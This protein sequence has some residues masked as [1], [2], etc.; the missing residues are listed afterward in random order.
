ML[1]LTYS[2][3]QPE[4]EAYPVLALDVGDITSAP[5]P[6][7]SGRWFSAKSMQPMRLEWCCLAV[8]IVYIVL[9]IVLSCF[10]YH[11]MVY[12]SVSL[13]GSSS[14][15]WA[16]AGSKNA[17]A[18]KTPE[19]SFSILWQ[20]SWC[21]SQRFPAASRG[22]TSKLAKS[23]REAMVKGLSVRPMMSFPRKPRGQV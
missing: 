15:I 3:P 19:A 4:G 2:S 6:S 20:I 22:N 14:T 18:S 12:S 23:A 1:S 21:S 7:R 16:N 5:G 8:Y 10:I 13:C 9:Y 17:L 11:F